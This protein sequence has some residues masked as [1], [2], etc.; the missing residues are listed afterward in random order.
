MQKVYAVILAAGLGERLGSHVPK[1]FMK[2]A[3]KTLLEHTI[4][5]FDT[6]PLIDEIVLVTNPQYRILTEDIILRSTFSKVC[7]I[8]N[9]G[10]TRRESSS[11]GVNSIPDENAFVLV[12]DAVIPFITERILGECI[13]AL[14]KFDAVDV[15]IP[16]VYTMIRVNDA[17]LIEEVP[18]RR[19]IMRGLT[20]QGFTVRTIRK[21]HALAERDDEQ[22]ATDDCS[23]ILKYRLGQVYVVV[24]DLNSIKVTYPEDVY[25]AEKLF[26][27]KGYPAPDR[28]S[29]DELRD[30][31]LVI[32]GGGRG[33]GETMLR[34]AAQ[35]G[36]RTYAFSRRNGVD[37]RILEH[38]TS[39]LQKVIEREGRIDYVSNTAA[40]LHAG[41]LENR[42]ISEIVEE[43]EVNYI[44]SINV[45]K[46]SYQYLKRSKG[47]IV[48]FAGTSYTRG[49][50]LYATYTSTKAAIVNMVQGFAEEF[51]SDA[52]RINAMN[53]ERV[54]G[55]MRR[56]NFGIE[57]EET[58]LCPETV[59]EASLK[60]L[61]S[62]LSGQV[63][64]I[65]KS[66]IGSK[67]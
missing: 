16:A 21:A 25:L 66:H 9:G 39:A 19:Y 30:R 50:A 63:V 28:A 20:P 24:G 22:T 49:R 53:P 35:H 45:V 32:F 4:D 33:I 67:S 2:I 47:S 18:N 29:L 1:Q 14:D 3:G 31:V 11:V 52:I 62:S 8:L 5:K 60:T 38:I 41:K 48:L 27:I 42:P 7:K 51:Q 36:A 37:V 57:P 10:R 54:A 40:V 13:S 26:Q 34:I 23:L 44:G 65:K 46:A 15:A 56:E 6:S 43:I 64:D 12:H 17:M 59:A 55:P 61:L 58:L